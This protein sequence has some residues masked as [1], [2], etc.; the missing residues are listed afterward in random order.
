MTKKGKKGTYHKPKPRVA[1]IG[2]AIGSVGLA[3]GMVGGVVP[4]TLT[5]SAKGSRLSEAG[6]NLGAIVTDLGTAAEVAT[7]AVAGVVASIAADKLGVNKLLAKV[8]APF[9]I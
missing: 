7:P 2:G 5:Q 8:K 3:A 6:D 1:V 4:H 9:R